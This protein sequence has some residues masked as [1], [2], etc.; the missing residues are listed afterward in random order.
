MKAPG[1]ARLLGRRRAPRG[2]GHDLRPPGR[3]RRQ[4]SGLGSRA[5]ATYEPA[6][7]LS[8]GETLA[9]TLL[10]GFALDL[11]DVLA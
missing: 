10:P 6:V 2:P 11:S 3:V 1:G 5:E 8:A 9:T 4:R 7:T